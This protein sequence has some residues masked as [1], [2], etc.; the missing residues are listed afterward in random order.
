LSKQPKTVLGLKA[1][2]RGVAVMTVIVNFK[3]GKKQVWHVVALEKLCADIRSMLAIQF[4]ELINEIEDCEDE[5]VSVCSVRAIQF[6]D[7]CYFAA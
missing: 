2:S 4:R 5:G 7:D 3:D 6:L 1:K